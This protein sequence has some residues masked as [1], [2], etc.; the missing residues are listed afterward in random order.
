MYEKGIFLFVSA[1]ATGLKSIRVLSKVYRGWMNRSVNLVAN[2]RLRFAVRTYSFHL[3]DAVGSICRCNAALWLAESQHFLQLYGLAW[4]RRVSCLWPV[5]NINRSFSWFVLVT[6][7]IVEFD[8]DLCRIVGSSGHL[9]AI[10]I[11]W[12]WNEETLQHLADSIESNHY[13]YTLVNLFV[14]ST[15][16]VS[17][18]LQLFVSIIPLCAQQ[19]LELRDSIS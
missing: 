17:K 6:V 5:C 11:N 14:Q 2:V 18:G 8:L 13:I 10:K 9:P 7:I 4:G 3:C 1:L 19:T 12:Q 15:L 16:K